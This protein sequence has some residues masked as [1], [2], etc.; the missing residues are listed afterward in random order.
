MPMQTRRPRR[1]RSCTTSLQGI[2]AGIS[3][4]HFHASAVDGYLPV[5]E[6][7]AFSYAVR[8]AKEEGIFLGPSS[9]APLAAVANKLPKN[10]RAAAC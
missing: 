4:G 6:E 2:G 9:G 10:S 8:A 7:D 5:T 3:P 1:R